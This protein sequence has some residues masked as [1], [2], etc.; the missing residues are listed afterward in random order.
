[1]L[2]SLSEKAYPDR[3]D[4]IVPITESQLLSIFPNSLSDVTD[5][6]QIESTMP[7]SFEEAYQVAL[8]EQG[9]V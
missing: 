3:N 5:R 2:L 9:I 4:S 6:A 1:M 8:R 7:N